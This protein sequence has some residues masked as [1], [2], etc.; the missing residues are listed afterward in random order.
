MVFPIRQ[1]LGSIP[2]H[3][4]FIPGTHNAG[5]YRPYEGEASETIFMRYLICQDES[6]W[7]QLVYGIRYL[8][9]RIGYYPDQKDKFWLN[10]DYARINPITE[11][12]T[13]LQAFLQGIYM[14]STYKKENE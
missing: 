6:I 1:G 10:H 11:L 8:D 7:N 2:L 9:V 4:L 14:F 12:I 3:K 13:S 5:S